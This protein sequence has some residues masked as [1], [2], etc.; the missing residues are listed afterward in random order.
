[1]YWDGYWEG[2]Y[3]DNWIS[4]KV[5]TSSKNH[6]SLTASGVLTCQQND[7]KI[8]KNKLT[9]HCW[10]TDHWCH[11]AEIGR[12]A[13]SRRRLGQ[14]TNTELASVWPH[15]DT[16]M[17]SAGAPTALLI[18]THCTGSRVGSSQPALWGEAKHSV[19][20]LLLPKL[21]CLFICDTERSL[22]L[23]PKGAV[24]GGVGLS[25][26]NCWSYSEQKETWL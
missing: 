17:D 16:G 13:V 20:C 7:E 25:K 1:M 9:S 11:P 8:R 5:M 22:W 21:I 19:G 14:P 12:Q 18:P 24:G 6:I 23:E 4:T 3:S 26:A 15:R 2:C 10:Y